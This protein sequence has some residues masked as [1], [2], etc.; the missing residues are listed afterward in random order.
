M[1]NEV[2]VYLVNRSKIKINPQSISNDEFI[3][4]AEEEGNIYSLNGFINAWNSLELNHLLVLHYIRI[5]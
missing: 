5:I 2:R 4:L 3:N 1:K